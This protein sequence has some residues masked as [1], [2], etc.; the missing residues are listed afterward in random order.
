LFCG[1]RASLMLIRRGHV[2]LRAACPDENRQTISSVR[3]LRA[4]HF[5]FDLKRDNAKLLAT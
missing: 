2:H 3:I 4:A 1:K 5:I